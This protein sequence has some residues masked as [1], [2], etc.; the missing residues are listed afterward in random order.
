VEMPVP[1]PALRRVP[2][3]SGTAFRLGRGELLTVVDP[4]GE[5]VADLVAF[6]A[7]DLRE[8]LSSGRT[9][10]YAQ[11]IYLTKG[12]ALYSNASR[13]MLSIEEDTVGR[14]DFLLTPCCAATFRI[15][16]DDADP[17]PGCFENLASALAEFGVEPLSIPTTFN[18]FMNVEV[19]PDGALAVL[20]PRSRAGD[21]LALRAK[22]DLI[23]G[24]TAC[25]AGLSNNFSFKPIAFRI[26][27]S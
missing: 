11:T 13:E 26:D 25:S 1:L 10:D 9:L 5:Q 18:I 19:G 17:H 4:H 23:V 14:H 15:L 2:P 16:Y 7:A 21:R 12:H 22:M 8:V 24:L 20:P 6:S 27:E 3:R